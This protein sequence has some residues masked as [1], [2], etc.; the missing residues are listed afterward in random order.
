MRREADWAMET[1]DYRDEAEGSF[2]R[3]VISRQ[4]EQQSRLSLS[5]E[6]Q[7]A[8]AEHGAEATSNDSRLSICE[9]RTQ[10]GS[11]TGSWDSKSLGHA[12][13]F[14]MKDSFRSAKPESKNWL[15]PRRR[16]DTTMASNAL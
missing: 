6:S 15:D 1:V 11:T 7:K 14:F 8:R 3:A 9:D 13:V 10:R 5:F 12:N 4:R 2:E 16:L